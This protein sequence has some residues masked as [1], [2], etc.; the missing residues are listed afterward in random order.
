VPAWLGCVEPMLLEAD[1][2]VRA[3][4]ESVRLLANEACQAL[5]GAG[6]AK[7]ID[8][9]A[10]DFIAEDRGAATERF[11]DWTGRAPPRHPPCGWHRRS[12]T[13][14]GRCAG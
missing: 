4:V 1:H 11:I 8:R 6:F 7:E 9:L 2:T 13:R 5:L 14:G 10:A 12:L 3:E